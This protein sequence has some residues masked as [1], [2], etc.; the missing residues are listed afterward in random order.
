MLVIR[1][2][3]LLVAQ[4]GD[5]DERDGSLQAPEEAAGRGTVDEPADN[6]SLESFLPE[7]FPAGQS[8]EVNSQPCQGT[9]GSVTAQ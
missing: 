9:A 8:Q 2:A 5:E 6:F 1:M 7:I 4:H 3:R